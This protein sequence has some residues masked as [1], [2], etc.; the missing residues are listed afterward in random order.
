MSE[1][2]YIV[3]YSIILSQKMSEKWVRKMSEESYIVSY[4]M[5]LSQKLNEKSIRKMSEES[6]IVSYIQWFWVK[7]W[8]KNKTIEWRIVYNLI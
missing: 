6:Y 5:I 7:N 2:S 4:T 8:M 3:S 1:E